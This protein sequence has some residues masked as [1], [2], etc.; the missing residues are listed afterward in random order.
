MS[1]GLALGSG[2][3]HGTAS[4]LVVSALATVA[5][6]QAGEPAGAESQVRVICRMAASRTADDRLAA[7]L[8]Q[9]SGLV[10]RRMQVISDRLL[11]VAFTCPAGTPCASG[12]TRLRQATQLVTDIT[13]DEQARVPRQPDRSQ[14]RP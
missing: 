5:C 10:V 8:A 14:E 13:L 12:L 11:A 4:L 1:T 3:A 7:E 2:L 6:T 9:A